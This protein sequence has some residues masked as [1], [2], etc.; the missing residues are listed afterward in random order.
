MDSKKNQKEVYESVNMPKAIRKYNDL[1]DLIASIASKLTNVYNHNE[2]EFLSAYRVHTVELQ[3]ELK[4]LKE[5][6]ESA[7]ASLH[8]D[9]SVAKLEQE[10]SWFSG[11]AV[12][13]RNQTSSMKKDVQSMHERIEALREQR[14]FLSN[15]LK[16]VMK[17]TKVLE[18]DLESTSLP[19]GSQIEEMSVNSKG[20]HDND[21]AKHNFRTV[22][23]ERKMNKSN[24]AK[25]IKSPKLKPIL[26]E[27]QYKDT[28]TYKKGSDPAEKEII[29]DPE[30]A[31]K[32]L[33]VNKL[34]VEYA[35]EE[36][37]THVFNKEIMARKI[38]AAKRDA[39]KAFLVT[40]SESIRAT[41]FT[42]VGLRYFTDTDRMNAMIRFLQNP[43]T[44][45]VITQIIKEKNFE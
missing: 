35:L 20:G 2:K 18:A 29:A 7:E 37:I 26:T 25:S 28:L 9:D 32:D 4:D 44:F 8:D 3:S 45:Q 11:E 43:Q 10:V 1:N 6:V 5:K 23:I 41:D 16:A 31:L 19:Q 34:P 14:L 30:M 21:E 40:R 39:S 22:T 15:Q 27:L 42:G 12:R 33:L 13:L 36:A 24:S 17:K 38:E